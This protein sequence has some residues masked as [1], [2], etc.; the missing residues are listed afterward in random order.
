MAQFKKMHDFYKFFIK[1]YKFL[2]Y[3]FLF[4]ILQVFDLIYGS[5]I[6]QQ[7]LEMVAGMNLEES[8]FQIMD[9]N[10]RNYQL[11]LLKPILNISDKAKMCKKLPI[12]ISIIKLFYLVRKNTPKSGTRK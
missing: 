10:L 7:N 9:G 11:A 4:S 3:K 6:S 8:D 1:F 2:F 5:Q 12:Y